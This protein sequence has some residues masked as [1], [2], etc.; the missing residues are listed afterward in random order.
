MVAFFTILKEG[1]MGSLTSILNIAVIIFPLMIVMEIAEDLHVLDKISKLYE[2]V[3][4]GLG[5]V[6][7]ASLPLVI[8][9]FFG[10]ILSAGVLIQTA[11]KENIDKK[12]LLLIIIFLSC[13]HAI[14]EEPLLFVTV[15]ANG[16]LLASIRIVTA[17]IL[18]ALVSRKISKK[19]SN[20]HS[21]NYPK[22]SSRT[23]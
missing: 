21:E 22:T 9:I 5:I 13:C 18:T 7:S 23:T 1:L 20:N 17:F 19:H 2:P 15:G 4:S 10:M 3:T 11:K 14:I 6:K 12:S 16:L 8:G